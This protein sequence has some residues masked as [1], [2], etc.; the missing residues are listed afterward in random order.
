MT[1]VNVYLN[2]DGKCKE[3]FDFYKSVFGGDFSDYNTY[4]EMP[5]PE[6]GPELTPEEKAKIMHVTLPIGEHSVIMGSDSAGP[7]APPVSYGNNFSISV[8]PDNKE[9]AERIFNALASDGKVTMPLEKTFWNA[10]FGMLTDQFG[11]NWMINC[12][13]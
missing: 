7:W 1:N 5:A 2:F 13:L 3:A 4:A 11:I 6:N 9:E 12:Q 10:Y 8:N